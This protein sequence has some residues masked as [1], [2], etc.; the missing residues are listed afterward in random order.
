MSRGLFGAG[1]GS[2]ILKDGNPLGVH[3]VMFVP[4]LMGQATP[5]QQ[6]KWMQKAF[7]CQIVGTYAQTELGHGTFLR[8]LETRATY[9]PE[10]KEFVLETPSLSAYKWWPGGCEYNIKF[11]KKNSFPSHH[12]LFCSGKDR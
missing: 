5:E 11:I 10:T 9:D 12:M 1:V 2:A 4:S 6:V 7:E 8:G 3:Y